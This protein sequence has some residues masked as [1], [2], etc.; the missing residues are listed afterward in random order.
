MPFTR[1]SHC[2]ATDLGVLQTIFWFAGVLL[3]APMQHLVCS[4]S[5]ADIMVA[6]LLDEDLPTRWGLQE[7]FGSRRAAPL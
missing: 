6:A 7:F 1:R 3:T 5:K 4:K 2:G